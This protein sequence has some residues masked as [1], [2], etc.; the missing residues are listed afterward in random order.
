M[1]SEGCTSFNSSETA[2]GGSKSSQ[3]KNI[4]PRFYVFLLSYKVAKE[5]VVLKRKFWIEAL[6]RTKSGRKK[7]EEEIECTQ[8]P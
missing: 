6:Y 7:W 5:L 8:I 4:C 3:G 1:L 2:I